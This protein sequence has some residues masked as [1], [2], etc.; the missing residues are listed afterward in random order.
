MHNSPLSIWWISTPWGP[1]FLCEYAEDPY[2]LSQGGRWF[3]LITFPWH[4]RSLSQPFIWL[5]LLCWHG[6]TALGKK[7]LW[8]TGNILFPLGKSEHDSMSGMEILHID[9]E[10]EHTPTLL[11]VKT[12]LMV[13]LRF[14]FLRNSNYFR[15][16]DFLKPDLP[17][18]FRHSSCPSPLLPRK[19]MWWG[20]PKWWG[21]VVCWLVVG[22]FLKE[23]SCL[24]VQA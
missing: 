21:L 20:G 2:I 17:Q 4:L 8:F 23:W 19:P 24:E 22:R 14:V 11:I 3:L 10:N 6:S 1:Q 5:F 7:R 15:K 9:K 16:S 13:L 18:P 12:H